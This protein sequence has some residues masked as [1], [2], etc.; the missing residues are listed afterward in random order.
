MKSFN[1]R[2]IIAAALVCSMLMALAA[3]SKKPA[4]TSADTTPSTTSETIAT[5]TTPSTTQS[6]L[7]VYS[8]PLATSDTT[9]ITWTESALPN[10]VTLYATVSAG[11]FLRVRKGPGKN[12]EIAGTLTR[13]QSVVVVAS[14]NDGWYK[15]KDGYYV[16]GQYLK[17]TAPA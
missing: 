15:T 17:T 6:N 5:V 1:N 10:E 3:C 14:T 12:Y 7:P 9:V 4:E 13:G 11:T 8:G 16:S 2:K